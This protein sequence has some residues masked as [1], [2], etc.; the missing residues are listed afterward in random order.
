MIE[1]KLL[2][3]YIQNNLYKLDL[4]YLLENPNTI[5]LL[6]QHSHKID[7]IVVL[8]NSPNI[9]VLLEKILYKMN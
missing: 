2:Y 6:R 5:S 8:Y 3:E 4:I 1:Q 7:C 9:I